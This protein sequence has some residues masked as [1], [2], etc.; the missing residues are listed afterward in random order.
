MPPWLNSEIVVKPLGPIPNQG[1]PPTTPLFTTTLSSNSRNE[2]VPIYQSKDKDPV[3]DITIIIVVS[4]IAALLI[5]TLCVALILVRKRKQR[6]DY[7][8]KNEGDADME[9]KQPLN[10]N[11]HSSPYSQPPKFPSHTLPRS[12]NR[13]N[14]SFE[15][16]NSPVPADHLAKLDEFSMITA[17][18]GP[19]APKADTLPADLSKKRYNQGSY[20]LMDDE[21]E[22]ISPIFNA[23]KQRPASSISEVLEELERRQFPFQ[24]GSPDDMIRRSHGEGDLEWDPQADTTSPIRH[25]ADTYEGSNSPPWSSHMTS[26]AECNGDSGYE[27]ESRPEVTEDDITPETLGDDDYDTHHHKLFSFH[28]PDIHPDSSPNMSELSARERLLRDGTE[29]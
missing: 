10:H 23:R 2:T 18:L 5:I 9:L 12:G 19:R 4:I 1:S 25:K 27:A 24:N 3:D 7:L 28:V 16:T 20:P 15:M 8:V 22:Y 6:G 17:I 29:V 26:G 21:K 14:P 11:N 13:T